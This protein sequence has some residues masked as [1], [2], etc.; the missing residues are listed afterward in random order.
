MHANLLLWQPSHIQ[1][2][3]GVGCRAWPPQHRKRVLQRDFHASNVYAISHRVA[4]YLQLLPPCTKYC[5]HPDENR[6][7]ANFNDDNIFD[8]K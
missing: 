8:K 1:S 6:I 4:C 5:M 2:L 7:T 3:R